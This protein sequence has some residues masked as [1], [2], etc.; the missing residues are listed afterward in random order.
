VEDIEKT[1]QS[2]IKYDE[3]QL[4][5]IISQIVQIRWQLIVWMK[6][7]VSIHYPSWPCVA[8]GLVHISH[9]HL[10]VHLM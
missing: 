5:G 2:K 7:L 4:S 8:H 9:S 10:F 6:C 1:K 3:A